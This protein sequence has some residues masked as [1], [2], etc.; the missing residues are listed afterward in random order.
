MKKIGEG[1]EADIYIDSI[2]C[3]LFRD[4]L[5]GK[6]SADNEESVLKFLS[7]NSYPVPTPLGQFEKDNL[8]GLRMTHIDGQTL[9]EDFFKA[10]HGKKVGHILANLHY[11][12]HN[13]EDENF[14]SILLNAKDVFEKSA[15]KLGTSISF[16]SL[17]EGKLV[18][19]HGDFHPANVIDSPNG[20]IVID[21]SRAYIGPVEADIATTLV[22]FMIFPIP[23][24]V[25]VEE[26]TILNENLLE[27]QRVY[28]S[29]YNSFQKL[30]KSKIE[31]WVRIAAARYS[32]N[33]PKV[34]EL[35][36]GKINLPWP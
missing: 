11:R 26:R 30:D 23:I 33:N 36:Q 16:S 1:I 6:K 14:P 15:N 10:G 21:W 25:S 27:A 9:Q 4:K 28:L 29:E 31:Q 8:V 34:K 17:I 32:L 7:K 18:L 13:I 22:I 19:S 20:A 12:L 2:I 24:D 3:K 35:V 5:S